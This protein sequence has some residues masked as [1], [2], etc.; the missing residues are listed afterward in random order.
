MSKQ[1]IVGIVVVFMTFFLAQ[2]KEEKSQGNFVNSNGDSELTLLMR[3]MYD[4]FEGVK[5]QITDGQNPRILVHNQIKLAESTEPEKA[6]S[7]SYQ[8]FADEYIKLVSQ[9]NDVQLDKFHFNGIVDN[10]MDCHKQMC[11]G[12]M[13]RIK[14]LYIK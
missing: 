10:C 4:H 6:K 7:E 5:N 9:Y 8:N 12:P 14:K 11:P 2:C 3:H 1:F 13:V